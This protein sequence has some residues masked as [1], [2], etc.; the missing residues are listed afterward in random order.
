MISCTTMISASAAQ[1]PPVAIACAWADTNVYQPAWAASLSTFV[2]SLSRVL[3]RQQPVLI[4][5]AGAGDAEPA[6]QAFLRDG[7][8][9]TP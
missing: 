2:R 8:A 4:K 1:E 9:G 3:P 5:L 6:G 7:D